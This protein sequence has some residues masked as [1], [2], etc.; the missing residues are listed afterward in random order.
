MPAIEFAVFPA[1]EAFLKDEKVLYPAVDWVSKADGYIKSYYGIQSEDKK[2]LYLALFWDTYEHHKTLMES[3]EYAELIG[4]LKPSI[5][6]KVDMQ[7][8]VFSDDATTVLTA[9]T[10]EIAIIKKKEGHSVESVK[11][12]IHNLSTAVD[13]DNV[14]YVPSVYG[15]TVEDAETF[16]LAIGWDSVEAHTKAVETGADVKGLVGTLR[17]CTNISYVHVPFKVYSPVA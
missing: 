4:L 6:G 11:S 2:T 12:A 7:H 17:S 13:K 3:K 5:G 1:S 14:S 10:T 16:L 15:P 8:V 9:P